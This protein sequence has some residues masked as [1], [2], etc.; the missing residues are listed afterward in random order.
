MKQLIQ[1]VLKPFGYQFRKTS[2]LQPFWPFIRSFDLPGA[3]FKMWIANE[4]A[5]EWY[6]ENWAE[7]AEFGLL[8]NLIQPGDKVLDMGAHHGFFAMIFARWVGDKGLVLGVEANPQNTMIDQAQITLNGFK[9]LKFINAAAAAGRGKLKMNRSHNSSV[10]RNGEDGV[11]VNCLTGDSL[12]EQ[13]GPFDVL[14]M[15]VE[16]F[17]IEA[18]KGC[19]KL[20]EH[21]PKLALEIHFDQLQEIGKTMGDVLSL[22]DVERYHGSMIVRPLK[23]NEAIPFDAAII[24]G[25]KKETAAPYLA[26]NV[27][28]EPKR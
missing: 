18:L 15:D 9:N 28:L 1:R 23:Y 17:E 10:C 24:N 11:L 4:D 6:E 14:K 5:V 3:V 22:I 19:K 12:D 8:K 7:R 16:G 2:V 26:V 13:F 27:F 25:L 21:S 20:L